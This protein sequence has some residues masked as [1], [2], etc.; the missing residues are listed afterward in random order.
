MTITLP[1]P[2]GKVELERLRQGLLYGDLIAAAGAAEEL[3]EMRSVVDQTWFIS[4][5]DKLW[6]K[7]GE[8]GEDL[9]S[10][11]GADPRNGLPTAELKIK[12]ESWLTDTFMSC[13]TTMVGVTVET[14][15][16]RLPFYVDTF[17]YEFEDGAWVGT[18]SLNGIYDILNYIVIWP[19]WFMPIQLQ[20]LS[21]AIYIGPLCNSGG[22]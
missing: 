1:E 10:L 7:I 19:Q 9:I 12:G 18:A 5:Y 2:E 16:L 15:G 14:G 4:V 3:A 17:D 6:V 22:R 13:K 21:H 8:L 20:I 11:S